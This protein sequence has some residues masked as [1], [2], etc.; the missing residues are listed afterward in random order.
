MLLALLLA[1][2]HTLDRQLLPVPAQLRLA[3]DYSPTGGRLGSV[4]EAL[5]LEVPGY[6][7]LELPGCEDPALDGR[8][9]PR[10]VLWRCGAGPWQAVYLGEEHLLASCAALQGD[11]PP[12]AQA[13]PELLGCHPRPEEVLAQAGAGRPQLLL[14]SLDTALSLDEQ[15]QDAWIRATRDLPAA[16]RPALDAAL[17]QPHSAT[18]AWRAVRLGVPVDPQAAATLAARLVREP[19]GPF[20]RTSFD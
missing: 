20:S 19:P 15:G 2:D 6:P 17:A 16:D 3:R 9:E 11:P 14:A 8:R 1:C 13:L 12:L 5:L 7:P 10:A 4:H 18:A